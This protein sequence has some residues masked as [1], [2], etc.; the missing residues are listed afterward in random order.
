M[1][2]PYGPNAALL[3][4]PGQRPGMGKVSI[5]LRG[6]RFD[7]DEVFDADGDLRSLEAMHPDTRQRIVRLTALIGDPCHACWLIHGEEAI[8]QCRLARI[9]YGE[10]GGEVILCEE[11]EPD[12][13]YWFH[14]EGGR[15]YAGDTDL[16]DAFHEWFATGNRA[17]EGYGGLEHVE[18]EPDAIP[19]APDTSQGI[20]SLEEQIEAADDEELQELGID[21]D[22][23]DL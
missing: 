8:E 14:E 2:S 10:P 22:D 12:F 23:L 16:E 21:L 18:E 3:S 9:V 20:P 13:L 19:E 1:A 7:E 15:E 11:H 4:T 17:P 6:W 5:G